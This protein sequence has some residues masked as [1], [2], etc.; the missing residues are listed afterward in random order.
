RG[1]HRHLLQRLELAARR[2]RPHPVPVFVSLAQTGQDLIRLVLARWM[3]RLFMFGL[4]NIKIR[5][6]CLE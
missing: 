3:A 6:E 5:L 4:P 2:D 1:D